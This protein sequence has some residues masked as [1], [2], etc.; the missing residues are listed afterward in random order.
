MFCSSAAPRTW[1]VPAASGRAASHPATFVHGNRPLVELVVLQGVG[2]EV[3]DLDLGV[4]LLEV[5]E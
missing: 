2:G 1:I 5:L 3:T 4:V